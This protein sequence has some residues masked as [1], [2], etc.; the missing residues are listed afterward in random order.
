M[1]MHYC[2]LLLTEKFPTNAIIEKAL[3][4]YREDEYYTQLDKG[5]EVACP[6]LLWDW[7]QIG[8]RYNGK[9]KLKYDHNDQD[10]QYRWMFMPK[11]PRVGR[12][13]RSQLLEKIQELEKSPFFFEDD[14]YGSMGCRDGYLYVDGGYIPDL[15]NFDE[16]CTQCYGLIDID[17]TAYAR[18]RYNGKEWLD[19]EVFEDNARAICESRKDCWVTCLDIHE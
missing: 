16:V 10:S 15:L 9:F 8:G 3:E 18:E 19:I 14:Y 17:G 5:N 7:W 2:I 11:E 12:L 6:L 13:F 4:P 1:T